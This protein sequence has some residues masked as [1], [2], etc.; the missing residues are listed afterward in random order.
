MD[1]PGG[2]DLLGVLVGSEGTLAIITKIWVRLTPN[3]QDYRTMRAIFSTVDDATNAISDIIG[4]GVVPAAMELMD[5]G[6]VAAVEEAYQFGFPLDAGAIVVI[7]L[8]GPAAGLAEQE[9]QVVAFCRKW[10]ARE[11]LQAADAK[12]REAAL[13]MPQDG[14]GRGG[15]IEPKL[16]HSRR[17]GAADPA[18]AHPPPHRRDCRQ[19]RSADCQR[20]AC[21]RRE[22]AP[23]SALR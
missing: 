20:G 22:R 6:I 18:A 7:E 17:G 10:N 14:R 21:R 9:R 1:D 13:E 4:A 3:P 2:L 23:D 5:Q 8:D 15:P 19:A 12:Q 16:L 11:V